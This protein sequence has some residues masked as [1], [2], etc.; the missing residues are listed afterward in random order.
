MGLERL[1]QRQHLPGDLGPHSA[2]V[3]GLLD[4]AVALEQVKDREVG[5]GFAVGHRG[6]FEHQP[7]CV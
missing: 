3:V 7:P 4:M 2:H 1:V 5:R 6:A